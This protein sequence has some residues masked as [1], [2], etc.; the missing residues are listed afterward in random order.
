MKKCCKLA[1]AF[2]LAGAFQ[3][4]AGPNFPPKAV[5]HDLLITGG[6]TIDFTATPDVDYCALGTT[7]RMAFKRKAPDLSQPPPHTID[8]ELLALDLR[9]VTSNPVG[10]RVTHVASAPNGGRVTGGVNTPP[11]DF[12]GANSFF[13]VFF[14]VEI[15][16]P[17]GGTQTLVTQQPARLTGMGGFDSV[18][19][20][21][22][23]FDVFILAQPVPLADKQNPVIPVGIMPACWLATAKKG[24]E[25]KHGVSISVTGQETL[26][27]LSYT[28]CPGDNVRRA[29]VVDVKGSKLEGEV[30]SNAPCD[31]VFNNLGIQ[32]PVGYV[33]KFLATWDRDHRIPDWRGYHFGKF[34][35]MAVPPVGTAGKP[36]L[37]AQGRMGGTH[38]VGT[39]RPPLPAP[40]DCEECADCS[41]FEGH[42]MA[43]VIVAGTFK[44]KLE[45]T[46]AGVYLDPQNPT[47]PLPCCPGQSLPPHGPF[48]MTLDGV[49]ITK[50]LPLTP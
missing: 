33:P 27:P 1:L 6:F 12:P 7:G 4:F 49:A 34:Q 50:C 8:I 21:G 38:G 41:H 17:G 28:F 18:A 9:G 2:L 15:A 29:A 39:H 16:Q 31:E 24:T 14:E 36:I 13:D 22:S 30:A 32:L 42:L 35:I 5:E 45:A 43:A 48:I 26:G 19:E 3:A 47:K 25:A 37:I 23:F 20:L 46:Y 44:G 10:I 11:C 40:H